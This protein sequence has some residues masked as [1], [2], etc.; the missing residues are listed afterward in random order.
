M[1]KT[2]TAVALTM[3]LAL[4]TNPDAE[5][6]EI[7]V[8]VKRAPGV[9]A[10]LLVALF[11][12]KESFLEQPLQKDQAPQARGAE[13][14]FRGIAKGRYAVS[15]FCDN[16]RNRELDKAAFGRPLEPIAMSRNAKGFRG[17]PRFDDAAFAVADTPVTIRLILR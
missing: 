14:R 11:D 3:T 9:C 1:R 13:I 12:S 6:G 5:A 17:P 10:P 7:I 8:H 16:N 2:S 4:L 15:A